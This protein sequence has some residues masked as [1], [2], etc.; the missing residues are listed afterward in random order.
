[1]V[2]DETHTMCCS[3][4]LAYTAPNENTVGIYFL[5]SCSCLLSAMPSMEIFPLFLFLSAVCNAQYGDLSFVP[6]PFCC[7]QCPVWRSFLCSCSCLLSAM[8][9]M[10]IFPLFLFLSAVCNAQYGDLSFV[11]VPVCCLQCPVWRSFLCSCSFLLSAMPSMEIFPLFLFLSAVCNAQYGDLSFVPVPVCCLQC[12]VWRSFLCSCSCLLSAMP[13]MEIFPLFL[14]L[15]AV[16]NAQYGDLS[17]VPVPVCCLQCPVWR[18]FLCSCSCLL[19]AMP[20]MEIFPLFLF[21]SAVCNAQYGDL[22]FVPVPFCCLQCPVWRSFLCSCSCLLSAMP[23]MEIFPLFLFLSAV[24]NA[25]YGDLS[26]VPVPVCCLQCPVWRSFLCSCS[27]LLSAMPSMEIFPLFLFLSA[28]CNAQYGDLSF[29]PVPVCCLQCPVWRS[30]LCSCSFLLSAMPSMEIFPLFLFLSA[31]CNAQYG[32]LS[33][34][35]VPVCCLQCP[36]WRSFLCSCS[37][38]LSAMPSMEIFPL[39]LF[40]SAVC[41]AQYGDLSFV[42]VPVCCLQCPVWRSFLC[43]CSCLLSAMPSMEIFPLFLF[44]SA[45]CNAQYG[46]L[47]FVPVPF[48]CLQCPVWRSFLCSCSCLLSAMPSM[49]IF[50]LFL[51]LSAVCN[52]QYGD[53]S[54]VPVPVCCLQCPVW[55]SFLC[56]CSCLLSAM[57]SMEIFPL[58]L[59]LS[60]V[61][62]AQYG[63]LSFVPV[64]VC[65]LQCPVWRSVLCSCSC[66]LSAM[67]SM[68]ILRLVMNSTI[69]GSLFVKPQMF[70]VPT[71]SF[72]FDRCPFSSPRRFP[73]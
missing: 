19:S 44:L 64:P 7:L 38:L 11:P 58:F 17:F 31:V 42:P 73:L 67:P 8:P 65:C 48:C 69:S 2:Y 59:F 18:S 35:P 13:S 53:L 62:N 34:V 22:S 20:S 54:F 43:S 47:S 1:M 4:F 14:F 71:V 45:V 52:A 61:C 55:R 60:A 39:F 6:V 21:L 12:P 9:S 51:F 30:F 50:P 26:F 70:Q 46:D 33:F 56:S 41:N 72:F 5:C 27:C 15:S 32:D 66:L 49:E 23:S 10:E 57:P 63:D 36:V 40:L 37:C 3:L 16:C 68:E 29:V 28:V 25:Q 24:C